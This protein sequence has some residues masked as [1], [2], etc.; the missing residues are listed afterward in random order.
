MA[1]SRK[2]FPP[3]NRLLLVA[4]RFCF[5]FSAFSNLP[6]NPY[7]LQFLQRQ[8]HSTKRYIKTHQAQPADYH[9]RTT[10]VHAHSEDAVPFTPEYC[11]PEEAVPTYSGSEGI[12]DRGIPAPL[13][14]RKDEDLAWSTAGKD[15]S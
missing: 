3:G 1:L 9:Q 11:H 8:Y 5:L 6:A 2:L 14:Y 15:R 4:R 7:S 12:A 13:A 10:L